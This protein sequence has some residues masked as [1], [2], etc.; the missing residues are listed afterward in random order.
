MFSEKVKALRECNHLTQ[1]EFAEKVAV[2]RTAVSKW[3]T[4]KGYPSIDSLKVISVLF[5]VTIDELISD[6]DV[7]N[8]KSLDLKRRK[9]ITVSV[10]TVFLIL[11]LTVGW[12]FFKKTEIMRYT[13]DEAMMYAFKGMSHEIEM[14]IGELEEISQNETIDKVAFAKLCQDLNRD[15]FYSTE[16]IASFDYGVCPGYNDYDM[17]DF[18]S[19]INDVAIISE[20]LDQMTEGEIKDVYDSLYKV[21]IAFNEFSWSEN[22]SR[23]DSYIGTDLKAYNFNDDQQVRKHLT[24]LKTLTTEEENALAEYV[25]RSCAQK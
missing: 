3:E 4:G 15:V 6:Y 14:T 22:L 9:E 8:K 7:S 18:Y 16:T 17:I 25:K 2:S 1:E 10:L 5:D 24:K 23:T 11:S 20:N 19:Y 21:C 13:A 12:L